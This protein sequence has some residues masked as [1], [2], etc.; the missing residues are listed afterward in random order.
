MKID[1]GVGDQAGQK[2]T[3]QDEPGFPHVVERRSVRALK[4]GSGYVIRW[5]APRPTLIRYDAMTLHR[6]G[7]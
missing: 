1:A 5:D 7:I 2:T 3:E 6:R 4:C